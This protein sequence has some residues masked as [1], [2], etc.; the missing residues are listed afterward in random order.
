MITR[1]QQVAATQH[2]LHALAQFYRAEHTAVQ[3]A[4]DQLMQTG[5]RT[6]PEVVAATKQL[7]AAYRALAQRLTR[8]ATKLEPYT[9][10]EEFGYADIYRNQ[11]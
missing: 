9:I 6:A 11:Q 10:S 4:L 3:A 8:M 7:A 2:H 5:H 1:G